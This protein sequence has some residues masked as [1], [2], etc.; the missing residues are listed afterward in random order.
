M[1][2]NTSIKTQHSWL[3]QKVAP[4]TEGWPI[5]SRMSTGQ[6]HVKAVAVP[7][8]HW[9]QGDIYTVCRGSWDLGTRDDAVSFVPSETGFWR[10]ALSIPSPQG[11]QDGWRLWHRGSSGPTASKGHLK[12]GQD[13]WGQAGIKLLLDSPSSPNA[14]P[15]PAQ[16]CLASSYT[17][18]FRPG[19][20]STGMLGLLLV[21]PK[22]KGKRKWHSH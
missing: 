3:A 13:R 10:A 15:F 21:D 1:D 20:S 6:G 4:L 18:G 19:L 17:P 2:L 11:Q 9:A 5:K 14:C 8:W 7:I 12:R 16:N 22:E